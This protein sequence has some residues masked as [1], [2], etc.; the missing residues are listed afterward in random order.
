MPVPITCCP[1]ATPA[2][3]ARVIVDEPELSSWNVSM[4]ALITAV[5]AAESV[6]V[7]PL[8]APT[9]V[10]DGMPVPEE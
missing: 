6:T 1:Y 8:S 5:G 10:D 4:P 7:R 3:E 2:D 9:V